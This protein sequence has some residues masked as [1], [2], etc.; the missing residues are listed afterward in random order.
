MRTTTPRNPLAQLRAAQRVALTLIVAVAL[1]GLTMAASAIAAHPKAGSRYAGSTS[2]SPLNG[3]L[4]PVTF[5]VAR[6]GKSLLN[7]KY[8]SFGC[9]G[10]GG[11]RPGVDYYT[12]PGSV[13]K[14]GTVKLSKSG[15]F[16]V[17]GAVSDY[18]GF[19]DKTATTSKVAGRFT[20][21]RLATGTITFSQKVT[22]KFVSSCGPGVLQFTAKAK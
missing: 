5:T 15:S 22:G 13:I 20:S 17:S 1:A 7:F 4:A 14:V 9:F 19:G 2:A 12:Q 10:A 18:S 3:F 16:S 21:A 6:N 11:F 8:S